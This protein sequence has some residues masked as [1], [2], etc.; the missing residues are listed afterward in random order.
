MNKIKKY[1]EMIVVVIMVLGFGWWLKTIEA[2]A[3]EGAKA[4]Q[5]IEQLTK[6]AASLERMSRDPVKRLRD[7][8]WDHYVDSSQAE[9]WSHLQ[10]G[11]V[12][13]SGGIP[14]KNIV[15]LEKKWLP[16]VGVLQMYNKDSLITIDT[17]WRFPRVMNER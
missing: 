12:Y 11:A 8:L 17:L 6:I 3:E 1:K 16:E 10:K 5:S 2:K 14:M 4:Q 13:D 15:F 9:Y 7:F